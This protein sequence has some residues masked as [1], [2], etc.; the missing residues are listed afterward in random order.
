MI[1]AVRGQLDAG[2]MTMAEAR[3]TEPALNQ[4]FEGSWITQGIS[5]A[6]E[7]GIADLL[8]NGPLTDPCSVLTIQPRSIIT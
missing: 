8:A 6:A 1:R 4:F 3:P 5:V 7:M 2:D